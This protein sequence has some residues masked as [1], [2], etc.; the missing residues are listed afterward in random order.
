MPISHITALNTLKHILPCF[1]LVVIGLKGSRAEGGD[2]DSWMVQT[3]FIKDENSRWWDEIFLYF[4]FWISVFSDMTF[5]DS[6]LQVRDM[7][8]CSKFEK[9]LKV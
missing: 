2:E 9:I 1:P 3:A 4:F 8:V 5:L 6:F 7:L